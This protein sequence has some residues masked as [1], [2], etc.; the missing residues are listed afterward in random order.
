MADCAEECVWNC[1]G[2]IVSVCSED[3]DQRIGKISAGWNW[4][5]L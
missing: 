4:F 1:T 5:S 2:D 3:H